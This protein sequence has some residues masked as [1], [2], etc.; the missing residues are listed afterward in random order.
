MPRYRFEAVTELNELVRG[1]LD[2]ATPA[3]AIEQLLAE[4]RTP[5]AVSEGTFALARLLPE[6]GRPGARVITILL[7]RL[8]ELLGAGVALEAALALLSEGGDGKPLANLAH[9]LRTRLGRGEAL[10][11]ALAREQ[12]ELPEHLLGIVAAG[13]ASGGLAEALKALAIARH[14]SEALRAEILNALIYPAL[15]LVLIG[16]TA[17]LVFAYVL[18]EFRRIFEAARVTLPPETAALLSLGDALGQAWPFISLGL[19]GTTLIG[20]WAWHRPEIRVKIDRA[21]LRLPLIGRLLSLRLTAEFARGMEL[22]LAQGFTLSEALSHARSGATNLWARDGLARC[23]GAMQEGTR[24][25]TALGQVGAFDRRAVALLKIGEETG[26]M[27]A[28]FARIV[29]LSERD[30]ATHAARLT[31]LL[32][33]VLTIVMGL[34]V[35]AIVIALLSGIMTL[36]Q[37]G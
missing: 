30:L 31:A 29:D 12:P 27:G 5:L 25:S 7:E 34:V 24:L 21:L 36:T 22:L 9:R 18:P 3:A 32:T 4:G 16:A 2:A 6:R 1:E 20:L 15:L 23:I 8:G 37:L 17:T 19:L 13:E 28:M 35:G 14:K 10:A 33:P 26:D 11:A